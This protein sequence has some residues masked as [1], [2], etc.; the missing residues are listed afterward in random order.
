MWIRKNSHPTL[1]IFFL[2]GWL[3]GYY[4]NKGSTELSFVK[5]ASIGL[6]AG[7][8]GAVVGTPAEVALVRMSADGRFAS[9]NPSRTELIQCFRLSI[10]S[11][12]QMRGWLDQSIGNIFRSHFIVIVVIIIVGGGRMILRSQV[13]IRKCFWTYSCYKKLKLDKYIVNGTAH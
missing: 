1:L 13:Y 4:R 9:I 8:I 7:S 11:Y 3:F 12:I 10:L 6:T 5:K 2:F